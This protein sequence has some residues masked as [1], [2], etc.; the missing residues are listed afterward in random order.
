MLK[1]FKKVK[2][3]SDSLTT[4][5]L[6]ESLLI[7]GNGFDLSCDLPSSYKDFLE[8]VLECKLQY[9]KEKLKLEGYIDIFDY[10]AL[11]IKDYLEKIDFTNNNSMSQPDKILELNSWYIIFI[12]RKL[13]YNTDWYQVEAQIASQFVTSDSKLNIIESIGYC[14]LSIFQQSGKGIKTLSYEGQEIKK[15]Y[16]LLML[17]LFNKNLDSVILESTKIIF[18]EFREHVNNLMKE[19]NPKVSAENEEYREAFNKRVINELFPIIT[20]VLLAELRELEKDFNDYLYSCLKQLGIEY[21]N[22]AID[23]TKKI[24]SRVYQSPKEEVSIPYN[25][26]S[27]NYTTPWDRG[28]EYAILDPIYY[29]FS[30]NPKTLHKFKNLHGVLRPDKSEIIFGVDDELISPLSNEYMFTKP[31]RT[32]DLFSKEIGEFEIQNSDI[33]CLMPPSI[34]HVIFYGHSLS[35]AD[36]SYFKIIFDTFIPRENVIFTFIYLVHEATTDI[37]ARRE[38]ITK[39]SSLFGEYSRRKH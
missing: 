36:Y 14:L 31:S 35:K 39:I 28:E 4:H 20:Q 12:D 29:N 27:F 23:L 24:F 13:T 1:K 34:K 19:F 26:I 25:I 15:I 30:D 33:T 6:P 2:N 7:V 17:N 38:L 3:E 11:L 8:I 32:L 22:R 16:Y 21:Q 37:K 18:R 10:T 9:S 5:S